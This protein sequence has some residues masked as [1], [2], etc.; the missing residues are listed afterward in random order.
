MKVLIAKVGLDGH[1]RGLH[2]LAYELRE[3][4]AEVVMLGSG[5]TPAEI[6]AVAD[7]EDVSVVGASILSGSHLSLIPK[8][9]QEL[10]KRDA[11][12]PVVCGGIIPPADVEA[13]QARG[14]AGVATLGTSVRE[15]VDMIL[16]IGESARP[17]LQAMKD[18][19]VAGR[20]IA[21][22][23]TDKAAFAVVELEGGARV[24]AHGEAT[25]RPEA[26]TVVNLQ[27]LNDELWAMEIT[28]QE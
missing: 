24:L 27:V 25:K 26:G 21:S 6:A 23:R 15:A 4:G 14:V 22:T 8:V 11:H 18:K 1:D 12:I 28:D 20:V 9:V 19:P 5:T 7:Q 16:S 17:P 13:L 2:M 10:E 3:R